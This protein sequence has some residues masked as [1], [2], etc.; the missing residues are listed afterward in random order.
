M[1]RLNFATRHRTGMSLSTHHRLGYPLTG[2][3]S[4][5]PVSV[6]P[7]LQILQNVTSNTT[8][9]ASK[10]LGGLGAGPQADWAL[11]KGIRK[12]FSESIL[13]KSK[14][15]ADPFVFRPLCFHAEAC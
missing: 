15:V 12:S 2:W 11:R 9:H 3:F 4:P 5:E 8:R 1:S 14:T 7:S 13:T 10:N 6:S